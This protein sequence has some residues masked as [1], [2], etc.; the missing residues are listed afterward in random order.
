MQVMKKNMLLKWKLEK[1]VCLSYKRNQKYSS[2]KVATIKY[3]LNFKTKPILYTR[4]YAATC[5]MYINIC[6]QRRG[7]TS[8]YNLNKHCN[9]EPLHCFPSSENLGEAL[10]NIIFI[11]NRMTVLIILQTYSHNDFQSFQKK[12][13]PNIGKVFKK[14]INNLL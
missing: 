4:Y 14:R 5:K 2:L 8:I 13:Y 3:C 10:G 1:K 12:F 6:T 7:I 11:R 9:I